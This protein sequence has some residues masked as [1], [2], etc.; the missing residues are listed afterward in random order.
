MTLHSAQLFKTFGL[1]GLSGWNVG[2]LMAGAVC[3]ALVSTA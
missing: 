2:P 1:S 3:Y